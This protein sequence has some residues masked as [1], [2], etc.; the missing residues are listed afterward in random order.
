MT[1]A[2]TWSTILSFLAVAL[3]AYV[4]PGPDWFV[5]MRHA[6]RERR[7]GYAAALGVQSGLVVH[8]TAA[9]LGVA[10]ILLASAEAFTVLK[11][12]G[13]AYLVYL[14]VQSLVRAG[15]SSAAAGADPAHPVAPAWAI[16][17]QAF[18]ANVLNPKAALFFVAVLP[19]FLDTSRSV[20]PQVFLLGG[21]DIVLGLVWWALFTNVVGRVKRA[22]GRDR[23]SRIVDR[24]AGVALIGLGGALAFVHPPH[25]LASATSP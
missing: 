17:R 6:S 10:A 18:L 13:A 22:L 9:A 3:L 23:T 19:Q 11:L 12:V 4:T 25:A 7:S 5:V 8:M 16:Y 1:Q 24:V 2:M 20:A 15:R 14:G 21:L